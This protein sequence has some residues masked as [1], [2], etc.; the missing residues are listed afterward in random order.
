MIRLKTLLKKYIG[1]QE[2][3]IHSLFLRNLNS[4]GEEK[5]ANRIVW[6]GKTKFCGAGWKTG[7]SR[8]DVSASNLSQ[9]EW[10]IPSSS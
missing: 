1:L 3:E 4:T 10:K 9:S 7:S 5:H 2:D 8:V 6:A